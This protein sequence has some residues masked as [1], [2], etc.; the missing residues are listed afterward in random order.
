MFFKFFV[1]FVLFFIFVFHFVY[2]VY[3]YCFVYCFS[4]C[5]VS[6][7]FVYK[8]TNQCHQ[9]ETQLQSVNVISYT[10]LGNMQSLQLAYVT[11]RTC[12]SNL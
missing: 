4:F 12:G 1:S 9:V 10:Y 7:L 2:S 3:L 6:F 11:A 5:A 8:S